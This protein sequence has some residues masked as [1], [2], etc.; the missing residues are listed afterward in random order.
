MR[1]KRGYSR[2]VPVELLKDYKLFAIACE[3][4]KREPQYFNVFKYLS[5]RLTV[6]V[7]ETVITDEDMAA[8][9]QE[10]SAPKWVMDRAVKYI[11]KEGLSAEDDLWFVLDKDRWTD[12]QLREISEY[13]D[14][15]PNWHVA[16]S[17]PCFEV[18]LYFHRKADIAASQSNTCND[19]K[20]EIA[21]FDKGGYR[22]LNYIPLIKDA[23]VNA[24]NADNN[25][26]YFMPG[27]KVAKVYELAQS[28]MTFVGE[29]D[30]NKF[31]NEIIPVLVKAE[32][33]KKS[34]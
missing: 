2:E 13:C 28:M 25:K 27:P 6:D 17:N 21:A 18:W 11:E 20:G 32:G 34:P 14:Q 3:G 9:H 7:V 12:E 30:F 33:K 19:F 8:T 29:N 23:I 26:G 22:P 4:S 1:K 31:L 5:P 15:Q 24:S 10:K 16:I